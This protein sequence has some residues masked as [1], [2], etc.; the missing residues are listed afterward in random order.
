MNC[1]GECDQISLVWSILCWH[2]S[3]LASS[4]QI[5]LNS[6]EHDDSRHEDH[7]EESHAHNQI[8]V[9]LKQFKMILMISDSKIPILNKY[10]HD[11]SH[12]SWY[13]D[14]DI[15][16]LSQHPILFANTFQSQSLKD[17]RKV[18]FNPKK[19]FSDDIFYRV[20]PWMKQNCRDSRG[21][22]KEV[23]LSHPLQVLCQRT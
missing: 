11:S 17:I 9:A 7:D 18:N 16:S 20:Q 12:S 14:S 8:L 6:D 5:E 4:S 23:W 19:T 2:V 13:S 15:S 1:L 22:Q 21:S 3:S 10:L